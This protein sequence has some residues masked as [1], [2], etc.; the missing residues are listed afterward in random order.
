MQNFYKL[1]Y[2][3]LSQ[4]TVAALNEDDSKRDEVK[5]IVR[6][7][8]ANNIRVIASQVEN[9]SLLP[10]LYELGVQYLQGY[11]IAEPDT[12]LDYSMVNT[13]LE[14]TMTFNIG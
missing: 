5:E 11:A 12:R 9:A 7:A 1:D 8:K 14:H 4:K 2:I 13:T 3:K 10:I 6:K